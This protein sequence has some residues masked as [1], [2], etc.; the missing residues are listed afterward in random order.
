MRMRTI[1]LACV[2]GTSLL[3]QNR[4][5]VQPE[6]KTV[7]SRHLYGQFSEHLGNGIYGGLWVGEGSPIPNV[8]GIRKDVVQ[9]LKAIRVPNLRWPGGCFADTY[10]W[11]DGIGPRKDRPTIVN[12]NWGNVTE[13][14]AFGTH[15]FM[16]LCEQIGCEPVICGNV[17]TGSPREM[18]E[19]LEYLTFP[20]RSPMADLRR[21]NGHDAPWKVTFWEVGNES[22][23]CGGNMRPEY[24]ADLFRQY[25]TFLPSHGK[26]S[27]VRIACGPNNDDTAWLDAV[28]KEAGWCMDDIT[29]HYYTVDWSHK[30]SATA[31]D[32]SL[33]FKTMRQCLRMDAIIS[34]HAAL[35]D[36]RDPA[37]RVGLVVD[38]WGTW[39]D[40]EPGTNPSFLRQQNTLRDALVAG[41]TLNIFNNHADRVRM[42]N[43]AQMVNVL[44]SLI[45]TR[46]DR[47]VL[48][49]TYHVFD[50]YKVHQ[51][52]TLLPISLQTEPAGP[53]KLPS[54]SASAS[55][56]RG[57]KTHLT[58]CNLD[59]SHGKELTVE[60]PGAPAK[61][62]S[63]RI[64]TASSLGAHNTFEAPDAVVPV[65]FQGAR[66]I[67]GGLK[68][69]L[70]PACVLA[71]EL[72]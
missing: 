26:D 38:E 67:P 30:G 57:G 3:A 61:R 16:D 4:L 1:A 54:L 7:I 25:Q 68:I 59:P 52:A 5:V 18:A 12:T 58:L 20:G 72:D 27:L 11:K 10:H 66:I 56:D 71:L 64:L 22:W 50:L 8:R 39:F 37:K 46:D 60:L 15:E 29:L 23:G 28:V 6:G 13:D 40:V 33:W 21:R 31:F 34:R 41:I 35:L 42:A 62:V 32:P 49:P 17:G 9:A 2:L 14:N 24:Y 48:T 69:Q 51:D 19:W 53:D 45:L 36:A 47:M 43:I 44:Q 70:P 65:S 63:G 55:R